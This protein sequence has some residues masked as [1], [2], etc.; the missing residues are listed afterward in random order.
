MCCLF[1]G[2]LLDS[3]FPHL[4]KVQDEAV[5]F[6]EAAPGQ[7]HLPGSDVAF[8]L[9]L[10]QP[11]HCAGALSPPEARVHTARLHRGARDTHL[12]CIKVFISVLYV[13]SCWEMSAL[14]SSLVLTSS[15]WRPG[16]SK[17]MNELWHR[18]HD[19]QGAVK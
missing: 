15:T 16:K 13:S 9:D 5:P 3:L 2:S 7:L 10:V 19:I 6:V 8:P 18:G 4:P 17:G 12:K 14:T 11:L 1:S